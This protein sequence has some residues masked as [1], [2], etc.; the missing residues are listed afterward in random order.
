MLENME[1]AVRNGQTSETGNI[2]MKKKIIDNN[3]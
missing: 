2:G 3:K 1:G